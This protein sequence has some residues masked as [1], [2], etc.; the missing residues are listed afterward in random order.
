MVLSTARKKVW[1]D[2]EKNVSAE[3]E[4]IVSFV[5]I[6]LLAYHKASRDFERVDI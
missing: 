1:S 3:Q 2:Y 5:V 4:G 6:T